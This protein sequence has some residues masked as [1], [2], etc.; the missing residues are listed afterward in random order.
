MKNQV[1]QTYRNMTAV[2]R[3]VQAAGFLEYGQ[4]GSKTASRLGNLGIRKLFTKPGSKHKIEVGLRNTI[5]YEIR[6][7]SKSVEYTETVEYI[8]TK[9]INAIKARLE[10]L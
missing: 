7:H 5:F 6:Q 9:D 10:A 3:L 8:E 4:L 2:I 1:T